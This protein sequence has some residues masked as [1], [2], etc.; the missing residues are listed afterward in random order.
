MRIVEVDA[1]RKL[2]ENGFVVI[3][4]GGGGIPVVADGNGGLHGVAAVIDKD[5]ACA[6][7]ATASTRSCS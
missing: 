5:L 2:I 6:L 7:L 4:V 3:S 1:I